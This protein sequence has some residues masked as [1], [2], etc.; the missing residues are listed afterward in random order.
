MS[1]HHPAIFL[2]IYIYILF[3][4]IIRY[5]SIYIYTHCFTLWLTRIYIPC[6][7]FATIAAVEAH[8][9]RWLHCP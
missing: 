8:T 3:F 1:K 5:L 7:V 9:L 6:Y 4:F 2:Y